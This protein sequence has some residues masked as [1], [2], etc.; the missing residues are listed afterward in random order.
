MKNFLTNEDRNI[1]FDRSLSMVEFFSYC[2]LIE[3]EF[4]FF[5]EIKS[6]YLVDLYRIK[7]DEGIDG[8]NESDKTS[9]GYNKLET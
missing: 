8:V 9:T 7:N 3:S 2:A 6:F 4:D 1:I 5:F